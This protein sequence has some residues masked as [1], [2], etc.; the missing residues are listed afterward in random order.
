[1][2]G[3]YGGSEVAKNP[4]TGGLNGVDVGWGEEEFAES[5]TTILGVEEGK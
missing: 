1:M 2:G 4:W 5:F 3:Y